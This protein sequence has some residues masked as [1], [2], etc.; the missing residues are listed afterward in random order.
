MNKHEHTECD[1]EL[2]YCKQCKVVYCKKCNKEWGDGGHTYIPYYPY[3]P[4][5]PYY[6]TWTSPCIITCGDANGCATIA[7]GNC[8]TTYASPHNHNV[9]LT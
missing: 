1:H 6:P 7:G 2:A 9:T 4:Y 5:T 3:N 8:T